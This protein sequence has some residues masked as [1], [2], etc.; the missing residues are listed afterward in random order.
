M[1]PQRKPYRKRSRKTRIS[2]SS[3]EIVLKN[4]SDLKLLWNDMN[5]AMI[6]KKSM[7]VKAGGLAKSDSC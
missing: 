5:Q 7:T 4:S 2:R 6:G 1:L 3:L